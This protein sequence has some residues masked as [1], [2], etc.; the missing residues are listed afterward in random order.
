MVRK[1]QCEKSRTAEDQ[2]D[3]ELGNATKRGH[4][5]PF[6][7]RTRCQEQDPTQKVSRAIHRDQSDARACNGRHEG[8]AERKAIHGP[9]QPLPFDR[10]YTPVD[11]HQYQHGP[12]QHPLSI[13]P[14]ELI[15]HRDDT[16]GTPELGVQ[17]YARKEED[18]PTEQKE[19]RAAHE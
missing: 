8:T 18:P 13:T 3:H 14:Y 17:E 6:D 12:Q 9:H 10:F 7:P 15:R 2:C 1:E 4:E 5:T 19:C 16:F 11:Q